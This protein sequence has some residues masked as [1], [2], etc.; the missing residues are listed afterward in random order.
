MVGALILASL[1]PSLG[2]TAAFSVHKTRTVSPP[3]FFP[4]AF[5]SLSPMKALRLRRGWEAPR[6]EDTTRCLDCSCIDML[7]CKPQPLIDA[8]RTNAECGPHALPS[9]LCTLPDERWRAT[10]DRSSLRPLFL[11][12]SQSNALQSQAVRVTWPAE[13]RRT[14]PEKAVRSIETTVLFPVDDGRRSRA[15]ARVRIG[16]RG[17]SCRHAA[18]PM[19]P[20]RAPRI[21]GG[22]RLRQLPSPV[23]RR[24]PS[25]AQHAPFL[26]CVNAGWPAL[27]RRAE[28]RGRQGQRESRRNVRRRCGSGGNATQLLHKSADILLVV[29]VVHRGAHKR[30]NSARLHIS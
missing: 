6:A 22:G 25:S 17:S 26:I 9:A 4:V 30:L 14:L 23:L 21:P 7:G 28:V 27:A 2:P 3:L 13:H 11:A 12:H 18:A 1:I 5:L 16:T 19:W 15:V 24:L 10:A 8:M 29:V 20:A